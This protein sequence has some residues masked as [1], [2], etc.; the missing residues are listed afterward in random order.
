MGLIDFNKPQKVHSTENHNEMYSSDSGVAGTYVPNMSVADMKKW[1]GKHIKGVD[2]RIEIRKT[3]GGTQLLVVVYKD[4][5]FTDYKV[6]REEWYKNHKNVR[7]SMNGKLDMTF[8]EY[9]ELV[10]VIDEAKEILN[11]IS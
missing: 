5:R 6:N 9:D 2:E 10:K 8:A 3:I 7:M 1:K 11:K 4:V